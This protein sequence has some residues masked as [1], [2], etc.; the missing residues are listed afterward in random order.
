MRH[1]H[2]ATTQPYIMSIL[3][4]LAMF[5]EKGLRKTKQQGI[6][7][8]MADLVLFFFFFLSFIFSCSVFSRASVGVLGLFLLCRVISEYNFHYINS[9]ISLACL[10]SSVFY[11][12]RHLCSIN[13]TVLS[14]TWTQGFYYYKQKW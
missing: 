2:I 14:C 10:Y 1:F 13:Y 8:F 4:F 6:I 5:Y 12:P 3:L 11:I 9:T 7:M